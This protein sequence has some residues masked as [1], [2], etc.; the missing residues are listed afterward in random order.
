MSRVLSPYLVDQ[1]TSQEHWEWPGLE[2]KASLQSKYAGSGV[3]A[4][5]KLPKGTSIPYFGRELNVEALQ[6]LPPEKRTH[7]AFGKTNCY[8]DGHPES[9]SGP[10]WNGIGERGLW[11]A[12]MI[13][14]GSISPKNVKLG[15]CKGKPCFIAL[16]DI[17]PGEELLTSYGSSYGKRPY[18]LYAQVKKKKKYPTKQMND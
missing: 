2:V 10:T 7:I 12:A 1:K 3:F 15:C 18:P 4:T 6:A 13:N 9:S 16:R 5:E 11:I 8:F 17:R 14:E